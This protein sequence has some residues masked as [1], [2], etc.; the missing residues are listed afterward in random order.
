MELE[1]HSLTARCTGSIQGLLII[2]TPWIRLV[3]LEYDF[4]LLLLWLLDQ[5]ALT[6]DDYVLKVTNALAEA[7]LESSNLIV[8]IDF[9]KS[10]E[11]TGSSNLSCFLLVWPNSCCCFIGFFSLYILCFVSTAHSNTCL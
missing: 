9:T 7:G 3:L 5:T 6:V 1:L 4:G 8:G 2:T 10:N 11:W